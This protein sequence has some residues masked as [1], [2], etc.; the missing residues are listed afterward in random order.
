M[1]NYITFGIIDSVIFSN[2][3]SKTENIYANIDPL[4]KNLK[5]PM[6]HKNYLGFLEFT[7]LRRNAFLC[8]INI[9]PLKNYMINIFDYLVYLIG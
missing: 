9:D 5:K 8:E 2:F 1:Y 4:K 7:L 6:R 3:W